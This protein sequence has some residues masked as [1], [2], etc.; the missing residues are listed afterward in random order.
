MI[1][2]TKQYINIYIYILIIISVLTLN[3]NEM[4]SDFLAF[5]FI[6]AKPQHEPSQ[7]ADNFHTLDS[8]E[9]LETQCLPRRGRRF[10]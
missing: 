8:L 1:Q 3:P 9:A 6:M 2:T 7:G 10:F 4:N 5:S